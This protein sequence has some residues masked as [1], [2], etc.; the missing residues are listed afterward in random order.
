[1]RTLEIF[2][3]VNS[4]FLIP[5]IW[6]FKLFTHYECY[7]NVKP[8]NIYFT[9]FKLMFVIFYNFRAALSVKTFIFI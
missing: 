8:V 5:S 7:L 3:A 2:Q 1:M 6:W 4:L 9:E